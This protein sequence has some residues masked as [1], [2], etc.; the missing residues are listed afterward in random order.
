MNTKTIG[1]APIAVVIREGRPT[2]LAVHCPIAV[3][4]DS[5]HVPTSGW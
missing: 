4:N 2:E 5:G 3:D 1:M